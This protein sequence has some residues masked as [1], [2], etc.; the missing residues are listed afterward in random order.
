MEM[1][2]YNICLLILKEKSEN[3]DITEFQTDNTLNIKLKVFINKEKV[4]IIEAKFKTILQTILKIS[5][6]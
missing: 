3:F 5:I 4:E 6:S 1:T 2:S